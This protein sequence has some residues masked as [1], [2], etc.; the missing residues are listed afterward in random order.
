MLFVQE[1]IV[2]FTFNNN[3]SKKFVFYWLFSSSTHMAVSSADYQ[4]FAINEDRNSDHLPLKMMN[5]ITEILLGVQHKT[6]PS[7]QISPR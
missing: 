2:L 6:L 1:D 5:A 7:K 4:C 3:S